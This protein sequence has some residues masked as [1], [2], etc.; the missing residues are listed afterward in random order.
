VFERKNGKKEHVC[1]LKALGFS[2]FLK[3]TLEA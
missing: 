3:R 2:G 1:P